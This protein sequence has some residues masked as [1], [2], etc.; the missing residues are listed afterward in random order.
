MDNSNQRKF[1][2]T[3]FHRIDEILSRIEFAILVFTLGSMI[4]IAFLQ[5]VLRNFFASGIIWGDTLLRHLVLWVGF[6]GASLAT[7]ENRH[8]SI[9]A[10]F[11]ILRPEWKRRVYIITNLFSAIIGGLLVR[12][13]YVF[14]RDECAAGTTLFL[15]IPL[16]LFVS[17][18]L[19]GFIVITFRFLLKA[20]LSPYSDQLDS[21]GN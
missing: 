2:K 13:A 12:A 15:G 14:V 1:L 4:F 7:R 6:L 19:I 5:V 3:F 20:F 10:L 21:G 9:D 11:R 17:A 18:I 16:W 8:I